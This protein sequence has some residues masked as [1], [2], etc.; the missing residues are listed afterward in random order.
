M[1]KAKNRN[2]GE[3]TQVYCKG[4][5]TIQ[6]LISKNSGA[7]KLYMFLAQHI[8]GSGTLVADQK[9]LADQMGC[10]V[11]TVQRSINY[12]ED[13]YHLVRVPV[14]GNL[15]AYALDPHEVWRGYEKGKPYATFRTKVLAVRSDDVAKKLKVMIK[16][17][18]D[19]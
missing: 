15:T 16:K 3:F 8:D 4:F 17:K 5:Q 7:A 11:R 12:L 6:E 13:N 2:H 19:K 9:I 18:E 10:S 14:G 1:E